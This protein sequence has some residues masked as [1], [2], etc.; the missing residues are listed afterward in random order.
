[1]YRRYSVTR[2]KGQCQ[3]IVLLK[4]TVSRYCLTE[5][6]SVT[7]LSGIKGVKRLSGLKEQCHEIVRFQ[8]TMSRNFLV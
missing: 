8:G 4:G 6:D 1:M 3:G 2:L 7:R 5:W